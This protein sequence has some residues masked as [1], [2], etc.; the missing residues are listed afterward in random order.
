MKTHAEII[1]FIQAKIE[2]DKASLKD[3]EETVGR[4]NSVAMF[5]YDSAIEAFESV[6]EFI[7][8]Q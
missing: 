7:E 2:E 1:E 3:L 8:E 6:I 5:M 4:E